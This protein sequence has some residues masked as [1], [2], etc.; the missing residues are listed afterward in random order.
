MQVE[1]W[2]FIYQWH[3]EFFFFFTYLKHLGI[4]RKFVFFPL[5]YI[6]CWKT[7]KWFKKIIPGKSPNKNKFAAM[8]SI[9]PKSCGGKSAHNLHFYDVL[10]QFN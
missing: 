4:S 7:Y 8:L 5:A 10:K 3:S 9:L 6:V 1:K 2:S